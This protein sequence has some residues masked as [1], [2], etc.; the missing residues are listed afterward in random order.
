MSEN[1]KTI[2]DIIAEK[3]ELAEKLRWGTP[4]LDE[5]EAAV[6]LEFDANRIEA[7]WKREKAECEAL[8]LSVGGMVE[9][10]RHKPGGNAAAMREALKLCV[11]DMCRYCRAE[12]RACDLPQCL[13]GCE[14]LKMAKAALA[15]PRNCDVGTAE[16]QARR[17]HNFVG[18]YNPCSYKG[19]ARCA[20]DCPVHIKLMQ[21]GHGELLCQL[22]WAQMPYEEGGEE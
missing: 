3:R 17:Y 1:N 22:E 18:R 8:A 12:A 13:D 21:E 4:S 14:T 2:A 10:S 9:A 5:I 11:Q 16:E 20:E 6:N 7:A 19:Y 15:A